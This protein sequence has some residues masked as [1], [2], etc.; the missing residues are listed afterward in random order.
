MLGRLLVNEGNKQEGDVYLKKAR[1]LSDKSLAVSSSAIAAEMADGGTGAPPA[2]ITSESLPA[3]GLPQNGGAA[4][5]GAPGQSA[6][7]L[8]PDQT[9]AI[10]QGEKELTAI[11]GTTF[12]DWGTSEARQRNYARALARFQEAEKWDPTLPELMRNLGLAAFRLGDNREA[13][14]ALQVAVQ[15]NPQDQAARGM[16]AMAA[17]S[18]QQFPEAVKA[19]DGLGD[20]VYRDPRMTYAYAFSLA[21]ANDPTK[22]VEILNRLSQQALPSDMMMGVGDLYS[23]TGDYDDA[24]KVYLKV[25]QQDPSLARAH[26]YAGDMLIKLGRPDEAIVQLEQEMKI[27]P[28]DPNVQYHFAYAF[29]RR[30]AKTRPSACCRPSRRR[31]PTR[32]KRNISWEKRCLTLGSTSRQ[33][34]TWRQRRSTIRTTITCTTSCRRPIARLDAPLTPTGNWLSISRSKSKL[35]TRAILSR[36]SDGTMAPTGGRSRYGCFRR[37]I[38]APALRVTRGWS[39]GELGRACNRIADIFI[40]LAVIARLVAHLS[41][42]RASPCAFRSVPQ[43]SGAS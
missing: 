37:P 16:L 41:T 10:E 8:T 15:Q 20:A 1:D 4:G 13:A 31:I 39:H 38:P 28:N 27:T 42:T 2:V 29:C 9:K 3:A 30:R 11:L 6:P 7:H 12:N 23:M 43:R 5:V 19:F 33:S 25:I 32:R 40:V 24:L 21:H 14:R 17:F 22:A 34:S 26:F 35:A 18:S 36:S